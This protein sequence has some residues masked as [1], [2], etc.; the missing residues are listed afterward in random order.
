MQ[1]TPSYGGVDMN[2]VP[3]GSVLADYSADVGSIT[4]HRDVF[5]RAY[6]DDMQ[7]YVSCAAHDQQT[8]TS[9]L[10]ACVTDIN[11]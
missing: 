10:L 7:I 3:Q 4:V 9:R 6:A 11:N 1:L 5:V 8:A 2:R